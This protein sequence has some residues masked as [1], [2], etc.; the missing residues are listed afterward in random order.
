MREWVAYLGEVIF[1]AAVSGLVYHLAPEGALKKHLHF[2]ISLCV[3]VSL[4]VPLFSIVTKLP[5]VFEQSYESVKNEENDKEDALVDSVVA[6][7]KKEIESA[8]V[9]Y[10]SGKYGITSEEISVSIDLDTAD[11]EA[12]EITAIDIHISGISGAKAREI[13]LAL[14]EMF[15]GR[16]AV[17]V[18]TNER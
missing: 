12:I 18:H 9:S 8:I 7:S 4:A 3:L 2:V 14:D 1:I 17:N 11:S 15:L 10:I 5:D 13:E 6:V 16:S